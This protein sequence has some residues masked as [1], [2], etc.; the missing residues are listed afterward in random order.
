MV[1]KVTHILIVSCL[2]MLFNSLITTLSRAQTLNRVQPSQNN[3][4]S[5]RQLPPPQ[6]VQPPS[7]KTPTPPTLPQL[8]LLTL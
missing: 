5:L 7:P 2:L 8:P 6:D 3:S 1:A 4:A